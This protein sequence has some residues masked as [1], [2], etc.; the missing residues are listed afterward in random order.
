M[1]LTFIGGAAVGVVVGRWWQ[2]FEAVRD[3]RGCCGSLVAV[4]AEVGMLT[5][6]REPGHDGP[7]E[8]TFIDG[9]EAWGP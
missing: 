5:C 4:E 3:P 2:M 8:A 7:H 6:E 1:A 9:R